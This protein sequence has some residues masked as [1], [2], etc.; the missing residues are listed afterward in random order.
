MVVYIAE[1]HPTDG[2]EVN[3]NREEGVAFAQPTNYQE[4][5]AVATSCAINLAIEM[6]VVIDTMDNRIADAYGGLP[7]RLYLIGCGGKVEFQG[8]RGPEG[9]EPQ[10]LAA[11]I[12]QTRR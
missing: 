12:A 7:D 9:F 1:I 4:R 5:E 6:P 2:W 10:A 11:A 8:K 3:D